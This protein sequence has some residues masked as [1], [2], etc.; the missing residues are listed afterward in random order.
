MNIHKQTK[1]SN[2]IIQILVLRYSSEKT[3]CLKLVFSCEIV[4]S[5]A[6]ELDSSVFWVILRHE[7]VLNRRFG[8][9][10]RYHLQESSLT[11]ED[12]N[13]SISR[14]VGFKPPHTA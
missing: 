6:V 14:N 7:V 12:G 13:D 2:P 5:T 3:A 11:L 8:S 10:Y 4:D 9:S 1:I